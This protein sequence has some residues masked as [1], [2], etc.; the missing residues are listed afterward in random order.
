MH[1][2][3][4]IHDA[5]VACWAWRVEHPERREFTFA[6]IWPVSIRRTVPTY[7]TGWVIR[8]HRPGVYLL[9]SPRVDQDYRLEKRLKK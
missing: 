3:H 6:I 7:D 9:N 8:L 5:R 2:K 1:M 4:I